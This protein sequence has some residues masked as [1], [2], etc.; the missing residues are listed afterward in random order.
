MA[1][2]LEDLCS[3]DHTNVRDRYGAWQIGKL[4]D[5]LHLLSL[6][7]CSSLYDY[8][9]LPASFNQRSKL[10]L[11]AE[12]KD[13]R[14]GDSSTDASRKAY[15]LSAFQ[16]YEQLAGTQ[17]T[18]LLGEWMV[19]SQRPDAYSFDSGASRVALD[20]ESGRVKASVPP[21]LARFL[22]LRALFED[23]CTYPED[24]LLA[25]D[26][27]ASAWDKKHYAAHYDPDEE[28]NTWD[29]S[30]SASVRVSLIRARIAWENAMRGPTA[31]AAEI[32]ALGQWV[33]THLTHVK[34]YSP[35]LSN[36]R[37]MFLPERL[38][39]EYERRGLIVV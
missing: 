16:H 6:D 33:D 17:A 19:A 22:A 27:L 37:A 31:D 26:K 32:D 30:A 21:R 20:I 18:C 9:C 2:T 1:I 14:R 25:P 10:V 3:W 7:A 11:Q 39:Q 29:P 4:S 5:G 24:E 8:L 28:R 35:P 15:I 12:L 13:Y 38:R 23:D 36:P 34:G